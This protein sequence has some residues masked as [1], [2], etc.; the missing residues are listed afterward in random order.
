M[1]PAAI[2]RRNGRDTTPRPIPSRGGFL[3]AAPG[4][5]ESDATDTLGRTRIEAPS[6]SALALVW[7]LLVWSAFLCGQSALAA[8]KS[9]VG[10]NTIS[11]PKGPGAIEGLGESFQPHLNTGTASSGFAL[12]L[13]PGTAGHTPAL[14]LS[15]DGG[16]GN[17]P[18][19]FG[20]TLPMTC[21]Q[22]RSDEGI[23]TYGEN[24]GFPRTDTFINDAREELV[25]LANGFL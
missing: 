4:T 3:R 20:W 13:P 19:G 8:D 11:L 18:L 7:M 14:S 22:R 9:G 5:D 17:G 10:P 1:G 24:V 12:Q 16:S 23:P 2:N 25:P 21:I 15:Y 6:P